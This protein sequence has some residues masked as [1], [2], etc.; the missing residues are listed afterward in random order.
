M[1]RQRLLPM[2]IVAAVTALS[3]AAAQA[4]SPAEFYKGRTVAF[5]IAFG[6]GGGFDSYSRLLARYLPKYLAGAPAVVAQNMP[7][8]GGLTAANHL[9]AAAP[10]DGATIGMFGPT[11][12]LQPLLGDKNARF[13]PLLF[14]WI[15]NMSVDTGA[16]AVRSDIPTADVLG[17]A[18]PVTFGSTGQGSTTSQQVL[19]LSSMLGVKA[20]IIQGYTSS[21]EI[22][23][24]MRRKEVDA[25]CGLY[26]S[27]VLTNYAPDVADGSMRVFIQLGRS[28]A[29]AF[30]AAQNIYDLVREPEQQQI[31]DLAFGASEAGRPIAAPPG[32]PGDR[33]A[34]LRSA[35]DAA[36]RDPDLLADAARMSLP[37]EP[38][39]AGQILALYERLA[40]VP[41]PIVAKAMQVMGADAGR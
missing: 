29:S 8:A 9:Y 35:F 21:L 20:K 39:S 22:L 36:M 16:C 24:A 34:A 6:P 27:H 25:T 11:N 32:V 37:I 19:I 1:T 31:L 7:G 18:R 17:G 10:K 14:T 38:T 33:A 4:Q 3:S 23:L 2:L 26:V 30:G 12:M 28:N 5:L 13:D 41:Q 15:G 40:R